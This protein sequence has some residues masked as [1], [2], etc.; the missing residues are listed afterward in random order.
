MT[1]NEFVHVGK[2]VVNL[3]AIAGVHWEGSTLYVHLIGGR[4]LSFKGDDAQLLWS[5]VESKSIDLRTG[6]VRGV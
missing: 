2:H 1:E 4:F 3:A 6:E 5:A